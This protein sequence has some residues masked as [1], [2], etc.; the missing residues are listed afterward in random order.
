MFSYSGGR[1]IRSVNGSSITGGC[2]DIRFDSNR[3]TCFRPTSSI[4]FDEN[5]P[6]LTGLDGD[7]W[8]SQ[9]LTVEAPG[10]NVE[11]TF[12]F[13]DTPGYTGVG[14]AEVVMF[15]CPE[16][17]ISVETFTF[18][19]TSGTRSVNPT[20][21]SCDSLVTVQLPSTVIFPQ[22]VITLQCNLPSTSTWVHLAEVTFF[23][24]V[25]TS[26]PTTQETTNSKHKIHTCFC[27][28][29]K[30]LTIELTPSF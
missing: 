2:S 24:D 16:L 17:G 15:N 13:T 6:T 4:L 7:M 3:V 11:F 1:V 21:T 23:T 29:C 27:V 26:S 5:V 10:N 30:L 12:N 18:T 9:L 14:G 28:T 25:F 20:T 8:A 22:Q 19:T